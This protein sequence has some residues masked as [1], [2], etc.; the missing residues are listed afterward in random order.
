LYV[1]VSNTTG[2]PAIAVSDDPAAAQI[3]ALT[4]WVIPLSAFADQSINLA[5]VDKLAIG[6]G[7]GG[8][9]TVPGG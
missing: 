5:D 1:A 9:M 2:N 3:D 4:E 8:N 7:T 6:L